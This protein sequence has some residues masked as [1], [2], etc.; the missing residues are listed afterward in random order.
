MSN[1]AVLINI[2]CVFQ[3]SSGSISFVSVEE[4]GLTL[5]DTQGM[6]LLLAAGFILGASALISEW[7]GGC[8]RKCRLRKKEDAPNSANSRE[9]LIT[10]KSDFDAEIKTILNSV[11]RASTADSR[12]SLEGT[13]I[14]LTKEN[15]SVHNNFSVDGWDSR[16]SSSVDIDREVKEIFE[17]DE[18]RRRVKSTAGVEL[19]DSQRQ[20]TASNGVFGAHLSE[21]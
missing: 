21:S 5:A 18:N 15:I 12:D 14:N 13:V 9:H 19:T 17:R 2:T 7:M 20:A 6:F 8:S 11:D 10:P 3:A 4:K 1:F 16:R